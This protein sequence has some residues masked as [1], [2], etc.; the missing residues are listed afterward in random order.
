MSKTENWEKDFSG[1]EALKIISSDQL[2]R[3]QAI[4]KACDVRLEY[5]I[6]PSEHAGKP[7]K[8][9][10]WVE[11]DQDLTEFWSKLIV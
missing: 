6:V 9:E 8:V 3:H 11:P 7:S 1:L 5:K 10:L 4:A 2:N